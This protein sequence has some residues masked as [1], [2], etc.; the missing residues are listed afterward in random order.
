[1]SPDAPYLQ[2]ST[3]GYAG[4]THV[5]NSGTDVSTDSTRSIWGVE[6]TTCAVTL[7]HVSNS[8]TDAS[9]D[10]TRSVW[11]VAETMWAVTLPLWVPAVPVRVLM[12]LDLYEVWQKPCKQSHYTMWVAAVPMW[13]LMADM[14]CGRNDVSSH[15]TLVSTSSTH[16]STYQ[17]NKLTRNWSGNA[18][19]QL[20][21]LTGATV[22]WSWQKEQNWC[23]WGDLDFKK[24]TKRRQGIFHQT[25]SQVLEC[26]EEAT[27]TIWVVATGTHV[28]SNYAM[29]VLAVPCE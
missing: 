29:W 24:K 21:Q 23:A 26:K 3:F 12:A 25:S 19:P 16:V 22:N 14:R 2:L 10:S 8:S 17:G 6:E 9:T 7:H 20:S 5:S 13:V 15:I 4:S 11:G 18:C 27:T 28:S 1:M